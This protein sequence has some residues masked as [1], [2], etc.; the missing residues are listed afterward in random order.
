MGRADLPTPEQ[1]ERIFHAALGA[2]DTRGV[3]AA[4]RCLAVQDPHRAQEL[5]DLTRAGLDVVQAVDAGLLPGVTR[6]HLL[7]WTK[8]E[9]DA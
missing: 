3:D 5:L 4:L 1:C 8:G 2:G 7:A 6:E 9:D